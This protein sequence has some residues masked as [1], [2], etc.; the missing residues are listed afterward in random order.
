MLLKKSPEL[1]VIEKVL[2]AIRAKWPR[3]DASKES[4]PIFIQQ[5]NARPHIDP[6]DPIFC[7]A[8]AQDGFN[9]QLICQPPNSP[10]FNVLDLEVF[11][12]YPTVVELVPLFKRLL[13]YI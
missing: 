8:A 13:N 10:D 2:P 7:E 6:S 4:K 12:Q 3:E 9:I 11:C 1:F 5:D